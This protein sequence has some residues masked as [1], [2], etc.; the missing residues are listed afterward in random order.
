MSRKA[1]IFSLARGRVKLK[2]HEVFLGAAETICNDEQL[3]IIENMEND[4]LYL[5]SMMIR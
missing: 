3:K 2:G 4:S 5:F 1:I